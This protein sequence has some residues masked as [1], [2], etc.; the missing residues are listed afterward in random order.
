MT[1]DLTDFRRQKDVFFGQDHHSPLSPEQKEIFEGLNYYPENPTLRFEVEIEPNPDQEPV[2]IQTNTGEIQEYLIYGS[3]QF[4]V[5]NQ[6]AELIVHQALDGH[7][8]VLFADATSGKE[9]YG[10]GRYLELEPL[11]ENQYLVDFNLAYNPW[12]AYSPYYSCPMPPK[13]N[14]L[15]VPIRAGEKNYS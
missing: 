10:A 7:L 12:C 6:T 15:S 9:T 11:G 8:T 4:E 5:E 3:F 1:I 2:L 13:E 14:R